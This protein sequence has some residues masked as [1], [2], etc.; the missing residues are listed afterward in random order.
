MWLEGKNLRLHYLTK[1]LAP[2]WEGPFEISQ[3]VSLLAYRL[4]LPPT[5]KIHNIFH[6]SLLSTYRET[7]EHGPSFI[8]PPPEEIDSKEEYK[9]AEILSH[10]GSPG[11]QSYLVSW[12]GYSS[13]ENTWEPKRNLQHAQTVLM[14]YKQ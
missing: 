5:W 3:V 9:V 4:R 11:R 6:T 1:K 7:A 2:K 8:N 10:S 14:A 13:M 12:K